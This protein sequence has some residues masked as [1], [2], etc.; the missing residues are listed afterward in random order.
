VFWEKGNDRNFGEFE[1]RVTNFSERQ[2]CGKI[3]HFTLNE[4]RNESRKY[5]LKI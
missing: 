3:N 2:H 5:T 4:E 1:R